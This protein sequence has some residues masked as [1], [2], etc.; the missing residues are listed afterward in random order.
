MADTVSSL[1][2]AARLRLREADVGDEALDARLLLQQAAGLSHSDIVADPGKEIAAEVVEVYEM[3]VRRRLAFEPVSRILGEREFYGRAFKITPDVLD[4]RPDTETLIE[5]ALPLLKPGLQVLDLGTGSGA[6]IVTLLAE[7]PEVMGVA[8]DLSPAALAVATDNAKRHGVLNRLMPVT[9][10]WFDR[11]EG[12]FDLI[13]SNPP[14]IPAA[15]IAGLEPDVRNFDPLL[16][17]AGGDDGLQA[18][19]AIAAGAH[20]HL[21]PQGRIMVEIGAGQAS[22]V[23]RIFAGFGYSIQ[24]QWKDLGGHTR[25]LAFAPG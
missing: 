5:A 2:V 13:V 18:Y 4:P 21:E 22:D 10:S 16:A 19:R 20:G 14:Y 15:D 23:G 6:I 7:R 8:V 3:L 9:G 24:G 11:V 12:K 1:L 25:V 17:L